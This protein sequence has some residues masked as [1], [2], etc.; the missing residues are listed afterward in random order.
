MLTV[1][2]VCHERCRVTRLGM[3]RGVFF[4]V[5]WH[6]RTCSQSLPLP[7]A[8]CRE[9]FCAVQL[10]GH[11]DGD[12]QVWL[13]VE[14]PS[15]L[16][17]YRREVALQGCCNMSRGP[18]SRDIDQPGKSEQLASEDGIALAPR[19]G[20]LWTCKCRALSQACTKAV[21]ANDVLWG[22]TVWP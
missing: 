4:V 1:G 3:P 2:T 5:R 20:G 18:P 11:V 15:P 7:L 6:K 21:H 19:R 14:A 22:E 17:C 16:F 12:F 8:E 9:G 10:G 13:D